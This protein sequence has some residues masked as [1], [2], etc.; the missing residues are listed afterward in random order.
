MSVI[1]PIQINQ[2]DPVFTMEITRE[3]NQGEQREY[4]YVWKLFNDKGLVIRGGYVYHWHRDPAWV[5]VSRAFRE[6]G[7]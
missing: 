3:P 6:L 2:N 5:L 1:V 7:I 4:K